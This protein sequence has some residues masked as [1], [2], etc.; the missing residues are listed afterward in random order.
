MK[1]LKVRS[2]TKLAS[3]IA[4]VSL[5]HNADALD[6]HAKF[7][8]SYKWGVAMYDNKGNICWKHN[9]RGVDDVQ[10]LK[11]GNVLIASSK[12]GVVEVTPDDKTVFEY[13]L[14]DLE[15]GG[16]MSCQRLKNGDTVIGNNSE[17]KIL[18][19]TPKGK[20]K[21]EIQTPY[22]PGNHSNLRDVKKLPNGHYMV[23]HKRHGLVEYDKNGK[24]V[25]KSKLKGTYYVAHLTKKD[26][27][28]TSMLQKVVEIDRD[29]NVLWEV[30]PEEL[31]LG[32]L[33]VMCGLDVLKNGNIVI[34][35]YK[36]FDKTSKKGYACIEVT[37]DKKVVWKYPASGEKGKDSAGSYLSV[38]VDE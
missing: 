37:R 11:N 9:I 28:I 3:I 1:V 6:K 4:I 19:V 14:K 23:C 15:G 17:G 31:G 10:L 20:V 8:T 21:R 33:G 12:V 29:S 36:P 26:T 25:W 13:P 7:L 5:V 32:Y 2:I 30:T 22:T 27:I 38:F 34:S 24:V 35:F 16:A 18:V